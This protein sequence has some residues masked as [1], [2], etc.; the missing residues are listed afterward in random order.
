MK[1][2]LKRSNVL[3][4]GS[5]KAPTASQMEYGELAVNYNESDPVLFIKDS[6]DQIIRIAGAGYDYGDIDNAPTIGDGE[7]TIEDADGNVFGSFTVNQTGD[8]SIVLPASSVNPPGNTEPGSPSHGD[9]WVDTSECPPVLKIY[10]DDAQCPGDGGWNEIEGGAP[11]PIAPD[12]GDGKNTITPPVSGSGTQLD[13]YILTEEFE[14]FGDSIYSVETISFQGFKPGALVQFTDVNSATNGARFQQPVGVVAVDGTYSTR[15]QFSDAPQTTSQTTYV[16]LINIGTIYY[17]WSIEVKAGLVVNKGSITPAG[18]VDE[19]T[20]LTGSAAISG[21]VGTLNVTH[22]WE[23]DG[24]EVQ[25]GSSATYTAAIGQVRY[26]AEAT[27]DVVTNPLIGAWSDYTTV[28]KVTGPTATMSGL[29]FDS[30]RQ[31]KLTRTGSG[32]GTISYWEKN[33]STGW[34]WQHQHQTGAAY[35]AEIAGDGYKS[36]YYYVDGKDIPADAFVGTFEGKIGPLNNTKVKENIDAAQRQQPYDSRANTDQVWSS[37]GSTDAEKAFDGQPA[38]SYMP[39]DDQATYTITTADFTVADSLEIYQLG[40][41]TGN[42]YTIVING[43]THEINALDSAGYIK[44]PV[45]AGTDVVGGFTARLAAG[46]DGIAFVRLDGRL[47]VDQGLWD[48]SQNWSTDVEFE[49]KGI[50]LTNFSLMFDGDLTT[51]GGCTT[52]NSNNDTNN[53]L[54]FTFN[55]PPTVNSNVTLITNSSESHKNYQ[56]NNLSQQNAA[57][58]PNEITF[59][60]T[61]T[62]DSIYA[63]TT[64]GGTNGLFLAGIKVDGVLL[65][66]EGAQW[67][68][69]QR[70]SDYLTEE[71]GGSFTSPASNGFDGSLDTRCN[72]SGN[73]F[74]VL[75]LPAGASLSTGSEDME[76]ALGQIGGTNNSSYTYTWEIG[77]DTGTFT[78]PAKA[79]GFCCNYR[80]SEQ[81][82]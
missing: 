44:I 45:E 37:G 41:G 67:N 76:F 66:D 78:I 70:W 62:L 40:A 63:K 47:L 80:H 3:E 6:N 72:G 48:M 8:G 18:A 36:D 57:A 50:G 25:R 52:D 34:V 24:V 7:I 68:T 55:N 43:E 31:T 2:Q 79:S 9:L 69:S 10:V 60:F 59:N 4:G 29:R 15:F 19:G 64:W 75:T 77:N 71:G 56:V 65:V 30:A 54:K 51:Q 11:G 35:P 17:Q 49:K 5:A 74:A 26:R 14:T 12:P 28:N 81:D 73:T 39:I 1:I 38:P 32:T 20:T 42:R 46:Q 82:D 27:D 13:P 21:A 16:G 23:Q 33:S 53:V 58:S 61:G 22:V